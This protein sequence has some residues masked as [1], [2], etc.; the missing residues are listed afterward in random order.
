MW[1]FLLLKDYI[2]FFKKMTLLLRFKHNINIHSLF[3]IK[4]PLIFTQIKVVT[5][6]KLL[7]FNIPV[8]AKLVRIFYLERTRVIWFPFTDYPSIKWDMMRMKVYYRLDSITNKSNSYRLKHEWR[9]SAKFKRDS[10]IE[11][12]DFFRYKFDL[13][14]CL[15]IGQ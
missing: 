3:G 12:L 6:F 11:T 14:C 5:F 4:M 13:I 15:R 1:Y 10:N 2:H 7:R 9:C 8:N